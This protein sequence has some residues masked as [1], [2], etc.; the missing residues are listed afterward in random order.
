VNLKP[1][2]KAPAFELRD[3]E[4]RVVRLSGFEGRKVLLYFYPR[5]LTS[6]CTVQSVAVRDGADEFASLKTAVVG[7]STDPP[8]TQK[9][10]DEKNSLGFPLLSDPDHEVAAKYG[11]WQEK[12]MYG[13]KSFG[14]VR[15]SFLIDEG[16]IIMDAWYKVSPG[17]TVPKAMAALSR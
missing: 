10:F 4:D 16:G 1:G 3:Q 8:A 2:D 6:G 11:V 14:I 13:K 12:N 7:I 9:R 15:S 17:D 5:A